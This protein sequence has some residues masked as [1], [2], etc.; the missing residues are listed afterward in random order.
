M[1]L[2]VPVSWGELIDKITILE[3]KADRIGDPAKLANIRRELAAL[4]E[5][6]ASG[7]PLPPEAL[8]LTA[9]L[10]AVNEAL[11]RIED[12][13]RECERSGDFGPRFVDLARSVYRTN[14]RR[15]DLKRGLNEVLQSELVEEKSYKPY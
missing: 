14:D 5:V 15:S 7:G 9:D 3:I 1:P 11:W 6:R 10:R 8:A 12:E 13:I 2:L 4:N